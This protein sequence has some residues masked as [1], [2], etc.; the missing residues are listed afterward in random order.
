M[1][2]DRVGPGAGRSPPQLRRQRRPVLEA[3]AGDL[4]DDL[5]AVRWRRADAVGD[6]RQGRRSARPRRGV[7]ARTARGGRWGLG[8]A[9]RGAGGGGDRAHPGMGL[10]HV[11]GH[12][13]AAADC[14]LAVGRRSPP[15]RTSRVGV[16]ARRGHRPDAP[17]GLAVHRHLRDLAMD[18]F[19]AAAPADRG[20][21]PV[22]PVLLVRAAVDQLGATVPG[23]DPRPS[24]QRPAGERP[25]REGDSAGCGRPGDPGVGLCGCRGGLCLPR[26]A[27]TASRSGSQP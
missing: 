26:T 12:Q 11:P 17:R 7:P 27:A 16:R 4:H 19:T 6:R 18:P 25:V 5:R 1:G 23:R 8:R 21:R 20:R 2:V 15:G 22:D 9:R 10:L 14:D 3:T 24:L 13:R